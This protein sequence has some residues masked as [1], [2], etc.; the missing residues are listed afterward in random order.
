MVYEARELAYSDVVVGGNIVG[1]VV[2]VEVLDGV[3]SFAKEGPSIST[4]PDSS[5]SLRASS[6]PDL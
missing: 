2:G 5:R 6:Q 4:S 1:S 3:N